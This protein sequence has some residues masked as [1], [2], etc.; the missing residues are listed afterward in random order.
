MAGIPKIRKGKMMIAVILAGGYGKRLWPM[1][2]ETA[3][4][5]LPVA[6]KPVMDYLM[7]KLLP[8][9]KT[10]NKIMV[11]TNLKFKRQFEN[12]A[13]SWRSININVVSDDSRSENE[14]PGAIG[15][16]AK[17]VD[18]INEDFMVIAGDCIYE[19]DFKG[20]ADFFNYKKL[21]AVAVYRAA[22]PGQIIRG[23]TVLLSQD[24]RIVKFVEKP[25]TALTELVGAVLYTFP[26][27]IKHRILEYME[28]G[29]SRDE[30]GRFIEWLYKKEA[31]YGYMLKNTV[32][33][34]G[35]LEAYR[36]IDRLYRQKQRVAPQN[37]K[38]PLG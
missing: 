34:I 13:E 25:Q 20:F 12:W 37:S 28:L 11:L 33:D 35:T 6:G 3:K 5:L 10:L 26:E 24:N 7:E 19:D 36:E 31:V 15:A 4:P 8:L 21:P 1:T 9:N 23:S 14:K 30:P 27:R 32:W 16:L 2:L 29:L 38:V 18:L 17:T 22:D